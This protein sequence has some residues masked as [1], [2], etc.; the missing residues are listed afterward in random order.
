MYELKVF[1]CFLFLRIFFMKHQ[2][3]TLLLLVSFSLCADSDKYTIADK[4]KRIGRFSYE[5]S[6]DENLVET[7][8]KN[9]SSVVKKNINKLLYPSTED[10]ELGQQLLLLGGVSNTSTTAIAKSIALRCG[11]EYY[12]I[13]ASVLLREYREGRQMLLSEIRPI[14][15]QGKP[16]A[17]II[18]ELPEM[19]DYSGLLAS[20]LWMLIDQCAQYPDV[21]VIATSALQKGQL[22][23]D[24]KERFG[25]NIISVSLNK[26]M[27]DQIENGEVKKDSW[28]EKNKLTCAIA[29]GAA[30]FILAA[31]HVAVQTWFAIVQS[32]IQ[33]QQYAMQK[34]QHRTQLNNFITQ[35]N[36]YDSVRWLDPR[37]KDGLL[38]SSDAVKKEREEYNKEVDNLR[39]N[40]KKNLKAVEDSIKQ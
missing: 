29:G 33:K 22:S 11:Y 2:V 18:T 14:I 21:L 24:I 20:T 25:E 5:D 16:I 6:F 23:E 36:I 28:F 3:S 10:D 34:E 32:D 37:Y 40:T 12:V 38:W 17:L 8:L 9:S 27:Q 1:I 13:E 15:K 30:C 7:V 26:S 31:T 39:E 35:L 19:A 4:S